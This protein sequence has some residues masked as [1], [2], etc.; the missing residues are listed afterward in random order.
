M[1]INNFEQQ[2]L[3]GL[4]GYNAPLPWNI[5]LTNPSI[6]S[7]QY[8]WNT[9]YDGYPKQKRN[10][11][12]L[13]QPNLGLNLKINDTYTNWFHIDNSTPYGQTTYNGLVTDPVSKS[14]L[15]NRDNVLTGNWI[16]SVNQSA[17]K[18]FKFNPFGVEVNDNSDDF[19]NSYYGSTTAITAYGSMPQ[20]DNTVTNS[21]VTK[22]DP[23]HPVHID[24]HIN[25]EQWAKPLDLSAPTISQSSLDQIKQTA[26]LSHQLADQT[27]TIKEQNKFRFNIDAGSAAQIG[28]NMLGASIGGKA[29]NIIATAGNSANTIINASKTISQ[30]NQVS[31]LAD[32]FGVDVQGLGQLKT[33]AGFGIAGAIADIGSSFLPTKSAY[34]GE[35]GSITQG[36]D[37][38]WDMLSNTAM[39]FGPVGSIVG[40]AMKGVGFLSK[41]M[42][43]LGGGTDGM[44]TTDALLDSAPLQIMTLGINGFF[45]KR[46]HSFSKDQSLFDQ[47]GS[48][49]GGTNWYADE[50]MRRANKKYGL[51]SSGARKKANRTIDEA[52]RQQTLLDFIRENTNS[53]QAIMESMSTIEANKQAFEMQGGYQQGAIHAAKQGGILELQNDQI[54]QSNDSFSDMFS[55]FNIDSISSFT[56]VNDS[57]NS[58]SNSV[59]ND[60]VNDNISTPK[61]KEGGEFNVIPDGALHAR[62][63]DISIPE[64]TQKGIPVTS[65]DNTKEQHAEIEINEIIYRYDVTKRIEELSKIFYSDSDKY[66]QKDK[67]NAAIEAGKLIAQETLYNTKDNTGLLDQVA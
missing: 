22:Y 5:S 24:T 31:K 34:S 14:V 30:L 20:D 3:S 43:A 40:G 39:A 63:N 58:M 18:Q 47:M 12:W 15:Q 9:I 7:Y 45:G 35:K 33:A 55:A 25:S 42:S 52:K 4:S 10:Q 53:R 11:D 51:F 54:I 29:G 56:I 36:I 13:K 46:A 6:T 17:K 2:Q 66:T 49:Y 21:N 62:K 1:P 27:N 41:G 28:G 50:A 32:S 16:E 57:S 8:G 44:T 26:E 37:T 23:Q 59:P 67:D 65:I 48:S 38:G 60:T 64:L 19:D 61:Y